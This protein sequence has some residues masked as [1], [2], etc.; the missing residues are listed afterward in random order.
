MKAIPAKRV[1]MI[2]IAVFSLSVMVGCSGMEKRP[3][4]RGGYLYYPAALV[5]AD[6]ALD[7][8]RAAGKDKE[9]PEE[10]NAAKDM[11]DKAY[12]TYMACHTQEAIDMANR[13]IA[14]IKALCPAKPVA[15]MKPEPKPEPVPPPPAPAPEP[16][17]PAEKVI[18]RLTVRVNFDFDKSTIRKADETELK[19][20]IDFV[21]KYPAAKVELDGY[22]D[23]TGTE[24][25]NQRLSERRAEAVRRYLIKEGAVDEA[26]ISAKG[27]GESR[28]IASNKTKKG[29]AE[30]R[31]VEI[32]IISE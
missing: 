9:C 5:N 1:L 26:R 24:Q 27:Y 31:R 25:Y 29:R 11:V 28:P 7:E 2:V 13:A 8:A 3:A 30:N 20:A 22:T 12:E 10:F 21:R 19:K 6:R 23:S 14:A 17:A 15:E 4:Y 18:D 32:I 16:A